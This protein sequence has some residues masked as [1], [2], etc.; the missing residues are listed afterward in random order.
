M[1][2]LLYDLVGVA[3]FHEPLGFLP[4][5]QPNGILRDV[6]VGHADAVVGE[7]VV[8]RVNEKCAHGVKLAAYLASAVWD[9]YSIL[10]FAGMT[11]EDEPVL[12]PVERV[13]NGLAGAKDLVILKCLEVVLAPTGVF[14]L[15][16]DEVGFV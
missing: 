13:A 3:S 4:L 12:V 6:P 16:P 9:V 1:G 2:R 7:A 15:V 11:F 5:S 14:V 8:C 10:P